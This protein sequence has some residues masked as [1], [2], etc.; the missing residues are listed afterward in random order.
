MKELNRLK[1]VLAEKKR[2]GKWL[3]AQLGKDPTTVSKWCTNTSQPDLQTL[4]AIA[5]ILGIDIKD[6]LYSSKNE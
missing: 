2:T 5:E 1:V 4:S 6:L 3:A